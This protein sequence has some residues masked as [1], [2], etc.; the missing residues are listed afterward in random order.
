MKTV[1]FA[2]DLAPLILSGQ[3]TA[4]WRFGDDKNIQVGDDLEFRDR[5]SG[6]VFGHAKVLAVR[7]KKIKDITEADYD[8]GHEKYSGTEELIRSF[9]GYYGEGIS[10]DSIIKLI[11]FAFDPIK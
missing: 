10:G 11:K 1:K 7:E 4:T 6:E 3:K 9:K 2:S 5:T 8:E